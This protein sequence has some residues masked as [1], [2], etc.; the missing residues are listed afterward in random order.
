MSQVSQEEIDQM[1]RSIGLSKV[2]EDSLE[3]E[4]GELSQI[5]VS[6]KR[7]VFDKAGLSRDPMGVS[8]NRHRGIFQRFQRFPGDM[9]F[10]VRGVP[11]VPAADHGKG[12]LLTPRAAERP[13][14]G[15]MPQ[16]PTGGIHG[17]RNAKVIHPAGH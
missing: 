3:V 14:Q 8:A 16:M 17:A 4:E 13:L 2:Q 7:V 12:E 11:A 15:V 6:S 5:D 9:R 10:A 1:S